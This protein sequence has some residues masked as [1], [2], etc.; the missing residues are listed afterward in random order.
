MINLINNI[1]RLYIC[2]PC[3]CI[4]NP[5]TQVKHIAC[6]YPTF[7]AL[8]HLLSFFPLALDLFLPTGFLFTS[9]I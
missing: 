3:K 7:P 1:H 2:G 8:T 4:S 5:T 9:G 6:P